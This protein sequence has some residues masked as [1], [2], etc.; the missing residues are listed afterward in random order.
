MENWLVSVVDEVYKSMKKVS[1]FNATTI[2]NATLTESTHC[3]EPS[4]VLRVTHSSQRRGSLNDIWLL[5][6]RVLNIFTQRMFTNWEKRF[7]KSWMHSIYHIKTS[8][9]CS[10]TWHYLILSLFVSRKTPTSKLRQQHGLGSNKCLYQF[11]SRQTWSRNPFFSATTI[12]IIS[13]RVLLLLSK[14]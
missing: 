9:N 7:L 6:V 14:D 1:S 2:T 11:L 8:K 5:A 4:G 12:L 13:C 10:R 3:S